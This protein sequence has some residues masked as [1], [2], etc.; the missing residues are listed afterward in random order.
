MGQRLQEQGVGWGWGS[1]DSPREGPLE[2]REEKRIRDLSLAPPLDVGSAVV[3]NP[4]A[5][6]EPAG[7]Q[8]STACGVA[9]G[10]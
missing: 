1:Q 6:K 4:L 3:R 7:V 10:K 9:L 5:G 2:R 8:P